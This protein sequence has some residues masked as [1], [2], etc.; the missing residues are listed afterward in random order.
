MNLHTIPDIL[1]GSEARLA[2]LAAYGILDT[3]PEPEFDGIVRL[4]TRLCRTPV[5]LV[6]FVSADRQWFKA[7]INFPHC[8]T[9]L[10]RSVCKFVLAEPDVL[11][12]PDLTKDARTAANPL[13]TGEPHI[14]FYA[15]AP[16]RSPDG[17]VL[18]SLCVID[19]VPR[20]EGLTAEQ[21]EDL[22]TLAGHVVVQIQMRRAVE[23]R[24]QLLAYQ[25]AELRQAG[26]LDVLAKA[27]AALLLSDEPTAVLEPILAD[28]AD[29]LGFD[30]ALLYDVAPDGCHL[31]LCHAVNV[32]P[33]AHALLRR[34]AFGD[35]ACGVVAQTRLPVIRTSIQAGD[36]PEDALSRKLGLDAY[37]GF[38]VISRG[39]LTAV[40]AFGSTRQPAFD[41][42]ALAFFET[43]ARLMAAVFERMDGEAALAETGA[44]WRSMFE[45]LSE[46]FVVGEAVRDEA[47]R[48]VDWRF[49]EANRAW[50]DLLG[51]DVR[52]ATG[53]TI[54]E[55]FPTIE[56]E[57]VSEFAQV[58]ESGE[59]VAFLRRVGSLGRWYEGRAF[60]I[61]ANRFAALF[62]EV[63]ERV[64]A[65]A[66]RTA[67]STL[68]D[69]LSDLTT[70]PEMVHAASE[71]VGTTL[72]AARAGFGR[73]DATV[74][75]VDIESDWTAPGVASIAGRHRFM[76]FGDI[77]ADLQRGQPLVIDDVRL[78]PRTRNDPGPM[79]DLGIEALVNVP[80]RDRGRTVAVFIV[81]DG[82]P[83]H[84]TPETLAFL[85]GVGQRL[86]AGVARVRAEEDQRVLNEEIAH[87]LKNTMAMVLSIAM[88][89]LREVP[90]RAPVE[91]F[92]KRLLA[93]STAHDVL[94]RR[95]WTAAPAREVLH[96]VL[97]AAGHGERFDAA[98]PDFDLG[99]RATLSLSL[100]LHELAT[101]A[102]KYGA[103][104]APNGRVA[105]TWRLDGA[106]DDR[107]LVLDWIERGGP[108]PVPPSTSGRKGFGS[109]LIRMGLV[110][111]GDVDLRYPP[112]GF[113][114][115]M[116]APL[117]QLQH[118]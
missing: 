42:E 38:P 27:S 86:E 90:D 26:R 31:R 35:P 95:T 4:A 30:R 43:L 9:D 85:H 6:S 113:E 117:A 116:R 61:G 3:P 69:R 46:G 114:A 18:G 12:I 81:Q 13:V 89:T 39:E 33:E 94:L 100:L 29:V 63:T 44:Y 50:G 88:Q 25:K 54:R 108:S 71:I 11:V 74:D 72:G 48:T 118:L 7:R 101:N 83:R 64:D 55:V 93:L 20:P 99:P 5:G 10:E 66:R 111:A 97:R 60:S 75:H 22:R 21:F 68:G 70:V 82:K 109:R 59:P 16:L 34:R 36:A 110:G 8:E 49:V 15:G 67:M 1:I 96:E 112:S 53:R 32:T 115:T 14:R 28:G 102:A 65:D 56:E 19:M 107:E 45:R 24:D 79:L 106:D 23:E 2:S 51:V 92:E 98:G 58:V 78:D 77:R 40:I 76:D 37:A 57:W 87:R 104:S 80:V 47:G 17:A 91:A 52:A 41:T 105:L 62:L 73:V 84:W 103:L